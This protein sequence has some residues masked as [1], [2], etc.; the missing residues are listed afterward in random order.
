MKLRYRDVAIYFSSILILILF[1][2]FSINYIIKK[3]LEIINFIQSDI[4]EDFEIE[5]T[6]N[7]ND[8]NNYL[9]EYLFI[10]SHLIK[11]NN[12]EINIQINLKKPFALNNLTKEVIFYDNTTA[13]SYY[14]KQNYLDKINLI[15]ISKNSLHINNYLNENSQILF[16]LFNINQIEYIDDRRY[17]L[18]L[19][20]GRIVMLPKVIDSKL[21]NFIK[22]NINLIDKSTNYQQFLDLRN[23]HNKTIRLK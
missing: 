13:S 23:F 7:L 5:I 20:N 9:K 1:I 21:I 17:N 4:H 18:V 3:P 10:E 6:N 2:N 11:R 16:S 22:N 15:D 8:I 19:S 12:N 14:F